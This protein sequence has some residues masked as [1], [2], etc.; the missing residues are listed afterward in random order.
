M[1]PPLI[2]TVFLILF[3]SNA[4]H[5]EIKIQFPSG[6]RLAG[7]S[8]FSK[9]DL[10]F[11]KNC[12]PTRVDSD[13]NG[14]GFEDTALILMNDAEKKYALFVYLGQ[15]KGDYT[16]IKL[17][18]HIKDTDKLYMGISLM[19]P[20]KHRTACGKGYWD[21]E[22]GEPEILTLKHPGVLFSQFESASSVFYWDTLQ[23]EF[24]RIWISD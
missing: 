20:G 12:V 23:Q 13:F 24:K 6:W 1:K 11:M 2:I 9:E 10:S 17:V 21:C 8:D 4:V 5:A 15:Q 3:A 19:E 18:E 16:A 14:D 7:E 22:P